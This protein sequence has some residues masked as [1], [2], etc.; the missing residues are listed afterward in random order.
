[1]LQSY[2]FFLSSYLPLL[3]SSDFCHSYYSSCF[4]SPDTSHLFRLVASALDVTMTIRLGRPCVFVCQ[5]GLGSSHLRSPDQ[6]SLRSSWWRKNLKSR[7]GDT[8]EWLLTGYLIEIQSARQLA[9]V[10]LLTTVSE[11]FSRNDLK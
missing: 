7:T 11:K 8:K 10:V 6:V 9:S 4:P 2:G 3:L 1:M 5:V